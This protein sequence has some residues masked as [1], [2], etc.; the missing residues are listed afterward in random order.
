MAKKPAKPKPVASLKPDPWQ[1]DKDAPPIESY[2]TPS[3][4]TATEGDIKSVKHLVNKLG[5]EDFG[6]IVGLFE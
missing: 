4:E 2:F 6:R 1:S 3:K 5:A